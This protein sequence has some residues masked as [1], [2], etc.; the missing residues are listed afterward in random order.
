MLGRALLAVA[1]LSI[2]P[3]VAEAHLL[4]SE[5]ERLRNDNHFTTDGFA[6]PQIGECGPTDLDPTGFF[7]PFRVED[8]WS[9]DNL[10]NIIDETRVPQPGLPGVPGFDVSCSPGA[11]LPDGT[12]P[13]CALP[14][15]FPGGPPGFGSCVPLGP[16]SGTCDLSAGAPRPRAGIAMSSALVGPDDVDAAVYNYDP[17]FGEVTMIGIAQAPACRETID[18]FPTVAWAGPLDLTDAR[19][20]E[21]LFQPLG[22]FDGLPE[23]IVLGLPAGYGIRVT[24]PAAQYQPGASD[25]R[26]GFYSGFGQSAWLYNRGTQIVPCVEDAESCIADPDSTHFD[27]NDFFFVNSVSPVD[28]YAIWWAERGIGERKVGDAAMVIGTTDSFTPGDFAAL[29]V[30]AK[31][32]GNGR[33]IH[34][35]CRDP[36]PTGRVDITIEAPPEDGG[37]GPPP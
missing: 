11:D 2:V 5:P 10:L 6:E 18:F 25:P 4:V 19:S 9:F 13:A 3:C 28:L 14:P 37:G 23:E 16:F 30:Q 24:P 1:A 22:A 17:R 29:D 12:N 26:P 34:G 7:C 33:D 31:A 35:R 8:D 21:P 27:N 32:T 15:A 20:G 36:R